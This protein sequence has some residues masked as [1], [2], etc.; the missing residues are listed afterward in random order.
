M[1]RTLK[2]TLLVVAI[3]LIPLLIVG[4]L[5][6]QRESDSAAVDSALVSRANV[7]A[8][9]LEAGFARGRT[10][11]LLM[12]NNPS[13]GDFY[14]QPGSRVEKVAAQGPTIDRVHRALSYLETL[15][16][17]QIGEAC[18]IDRSGVENARVVRGSNAL[19]S[20]PVGRLP[21]R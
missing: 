3:G 10:I 11:A 20:E 13:F 18:F 14:V 7:Q 21:P 4:V 5:I 9:E 8:T 16:P 17:C 2:L 19:P 15:Y 12:S 6:T 1:S